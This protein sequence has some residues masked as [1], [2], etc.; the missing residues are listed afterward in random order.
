MDGI[1]NHPAKANIPVIELY[2]VSQKSCHGLYI[3]QI[4]Y[5]LVLSKKL[6][7]KLRK[8]VMYVCLMHRDGLGAT[9]LL[10]CISA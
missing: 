9:L 1:G 3:M 2:L 8:I 5:I 6:F 4:L 10:L 7:D